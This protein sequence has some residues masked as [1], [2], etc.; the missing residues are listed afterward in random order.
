[1]IAINKGALADLRQLE[2]IEGPNLLLRLVRPE[3][4]NYVRALRVDPA[5]NRHLS[6][7][8]GTAEG[9][10]R[11]IETYKARRADLRSSTT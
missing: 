9:Q 6:A 7:A 8:R 3:D 4:A 11:W 10:H 2:R 5:Y 1:M